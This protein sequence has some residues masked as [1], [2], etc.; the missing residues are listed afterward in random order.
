MREHDVSAATD[1][2]SRRLSSSSARISSSVAT[3]SGLGGGPEAINLGGVSKPDIFAQL[4]VQFFDPDRSHAK[5][6]KAD[7]KFVKHYRES[8][9]GISRW[10]AIFGCLFASLS[11]VMNFR[12]HR[13]EFE[14]EQTHGRRASGVFH[15]EGQPIH[16]RR[17]T[18]TWRQTPRQVTLYSSKCNLM[19]GPQALLAFL[20][21][22]DVQ[23][24]LERRAGDLLDM[25]NEGSQHRTDEHVR[26]SRARSLFRERL[27]VSMR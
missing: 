26:R 21:I 14:P 1:H 2:R 8:G 16:N 4:D 19:S 15:E 9:W 20:G 17:V 13:T 7:R 11:L 22:Q 23:D 27:A 5:Q 10:S 18:T 6:V 25:I 24:V 3:G 12:N